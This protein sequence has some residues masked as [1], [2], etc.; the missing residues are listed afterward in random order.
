LQ[1]CYRKELRWCG[2][3][4]RLTGVQPQVISNFQIHPVEFSQIATYRQ[5]VVRRVIF[6]LPQMG[7]LSLKA[8]NPFQSDL[9]F[10]IIP[11]HL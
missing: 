9:E 10:L 5:P 2:N 11:Y 7:Y 6:D 1:G 4:G 8:P 3:D